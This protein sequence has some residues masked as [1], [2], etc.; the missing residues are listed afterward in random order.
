MECVGYLIKRKRNNMATIKEQEDLIARLKFT[1]CSYTITMWGYGGETVMGTVDRKVFDYFKHRRLSVSDWAW[2]YDAVDELKVP[3]DLQPFSPGSWYECDDLAHAS[4]A[5][6]DSGTL[7]ITDENGTT[8]T[9]RDLSGLDGTD[10]NLCCNDEAWVGMVKPG[11]VVFIGRSTEKGTF[12]EGDIDLTE[13]FDPELLTIG[14]DEIDGE[15]IVNYVEYNDQQIE[16]SGGSTNGKSSDFGFYLVKED[17]TW[18]KYHDHNDIKYTLTDWFSKK[19]NPVHPGNYEVEPVG[20][21][22]YTYHARWTGTR[23]ITSWAD[24]TDETESIKIRRWRG[25]DHDPD[26][27]VEWDPV[28]ELD[29]IIVQHKETLEEIKADPR[30]WPF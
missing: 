4:G 18:E 28:V 26:A 25:I 16:N 14:Y 21:K 22:S 20:P 5:S 19:V 7:Q 30:G 12:F 17:G 8:V 10:I 15:E 29:K 27:D 6:R 24:D 9:E 13:P 2:D 3:E 23:W 11:T 1:P